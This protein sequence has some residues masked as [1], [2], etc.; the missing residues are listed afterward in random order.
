MIAL[1]GLL[2]NGTGFIRRHFRLCG[3]REVRLDGGG[4]GRIEIEVDI[5]LADL[6]FRV[7]GM[8]LGRDRLG[9]GGRLRRSVEV[10]VVGR[11][12]AHQFLLKIDREIGRI[13]MVGGMAVLAIGI[14]RRGFGLSLPRRLFRL[15]LLD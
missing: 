7:L 8:H 14:A 13:V 1:D 2:G 3:R 5:Q 6:G 9:F 11:E 4:H 15:C 10:I 12:L